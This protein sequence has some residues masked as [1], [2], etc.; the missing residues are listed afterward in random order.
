MSSYSV[1]ELIEA[2]SGG[3]TSGLAEA[4]SDRQILTF[5]ALVK[6]IAENGFASPEAFARETGLSLGASA[7]LLVDLAASGM[8]VDGNGHVVGAALTTRRTPHR[9]LLGGRDLYAWCALDTLFLPGLLDQTAEVRST[10]PVTGAEIRLTVAPDRVEECAPP[11]TVL[12]VVVP[13]DSHTG[14]TGPAS[15]T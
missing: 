10:C 11:G 4:E 14:R 5:T 13:G 8:E 7:D 6:L 1:R 2:W 9:L 12:T 3:G 15:P